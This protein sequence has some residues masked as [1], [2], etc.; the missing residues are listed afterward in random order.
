MKNKKKIIISNRLPIQIERK[1]DKLIIKP[2]AGGLAT[3]LNS[4]FDSTEICWVG[5]P[6]IVPKD[7]SEKEKI[8]ALLKPMNLLPVFLS[9][10]EIHNFTKA[11]P[12][13]SSGRSA[14]ISRAIFTLTGNTGR[15][16]LLSIKNFVMLH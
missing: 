5:W 7:N 4:A 12:M 11:T 6:G 16:M 1:K 13:R 9:K 10:E 8:I 15:P 14:I 3:G 2:S